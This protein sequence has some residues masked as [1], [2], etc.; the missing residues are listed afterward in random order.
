MFFCLQKKIAMQR[1]TKQQ[2]IAAAAAQIGV[3]NGSTLNAPRK[4][5]TSCEQNSRLCSPWRSTHRSNKA[6][7][8]RKVSRGCT[9]LHPRRYSFARYCHKNS[10][11]FTATILPKLTHV[12]SITRRFLRPNFTKLGKSMCKVRTEITWRW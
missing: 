11:D 1:T 9:C 6:F 5:W 3:P 4:Y 8:T 12:N 7:F 2:E 10:M